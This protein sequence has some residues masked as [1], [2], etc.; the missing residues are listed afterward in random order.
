MRCHAQCFGMLNPAQAHTCLRLSDEAVH[1][2]IFVA[3]NSH[4]VI[5]KER[6]DQ[7]PRGKMSR[8]AN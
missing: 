6:Q 8:T 1:T 2:F 5:T 3:L 7:V 4:V